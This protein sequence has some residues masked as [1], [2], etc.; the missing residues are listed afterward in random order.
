MLEKG[1]VCLDLARSHVQLVL[2]VHRIFSRHLA[3]LRSD[4]RGDRRDW[5][6]G[7]T[8]THRQGPQHR[9]DPLI[10]TLELSHPVLRLGHSSG[11]DREYRTRIVLRLAAHRV[12]EVALDGRVAVTAFL[13]VFVLGTGVFLF[14]TLEQH[15]GCF[16]CALEGRLQRQCLRRTGSPDQG[17]AK[18]G[19]HSRAR[20]QLEVDPLDS[21][22]KDNCHGCTESWANRS[23]TKNTAVSPRV[24][25]CKKGSREITY[26]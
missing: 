21:S 26:Q 19:T 4:T 23:E 7:M 6:A 20:S 11:D 10:R 12:A 8:G 3:V 16:R 13:A 18:A 9:L 14:R 2:A 15:L 5:T 17:S 24:Q 1:D 22:P 25:V